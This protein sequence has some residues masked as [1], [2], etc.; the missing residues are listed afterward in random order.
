MH[1]HSEVPQSGEHAYTIQ[2]GGTADGKS[3]RDP[4]G[5]GY[6]Q[7][8]WENNVALSMENVGHEVVVNPRIFVNGMSRWHSLE[9]IVCDLIDDGMS[10]AEK[11]RAIWEFARRHRYHNTTADDEVKD[12]VKMLNVYGYTLCWDEAYTVSNLWQAA[13]L[14]VRRGVPHGHCTTEVFYDGTHHLLDSDEH[15]LY[16]LR[17]N[18]TVAGEEDLARDHDLVKRGHAYGVLS[19]ENRQSDESAAALFV[20]EGPRSGGRPQVGTHRMDYSLR[21][22][23]ALIWQWQDRGLY[24]GYGKRPP[25]MCNGAWHFVPRLDTTFNRWCVRA[26]NARSIDGSLY[27]VDPSK[28]IRL[29]Y[30]LQTPYVI[31]GGL[32]RYAGD[33]AARCTLSRDGHSWQPIDSD[34]TLN[35]LLPSD[36]SATYDLYLR[37]EGVAERIDRITVELDLQMAPL[38]LPSLSVGENELLYTDESADRAVVLTHSWNERGDL[39]APPPPRLT[40]PTDGQTTDGTQPLFSWEPAPGAADYQFELSPSP[41]M[42]YALSPVFEK[43]ISNTPFAKQTCWRPPENGQLNPEHTYFWRVRA[44][45]DE[46]L[47]G[48][49]SDTASFTPSAPGIPLDVELHTDWQTRSQYLRWRNNPQGNTPVRYIVYA[50][51]ERGFSARDDEHEVFCGR[52]VGMETRAGNRFAETDRTELQVVGAGDF[53]VNKSYYRVISLD[54]RGTPSGP[55][56]LACASRPFIFSQPP[57]HIRAEAETHY[58]VQSLQGAGDLRCI[59]EGTHRYQSAI[60]DFDTLSFILDEGPAFISLD[61][62]SGLMVFKP[63]AHHLGLHTVTLRVQNGQGGV[64]IQG[65]DLEVIDPH[66]Q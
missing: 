48:A 65:F 11:A 64:D 66:L 32:I 51:D 52:D 1:R 21:P 8:Y 56:D 38:S 47:W 37:I 5:Y 17:D 3:M 6:Y 18:A 46:G 22:G 13:G 33:L 29:I 58:A 28:P 26:D 42:R 19:R 54:E 23:E 15:L 43:L 63:A 35:A 41:D 4:V 20:Y 50:S 49:W 27:S 62:V 10:E 9:E 44:R 59:S 57:Q 55:S 16:L 2:V 14:P 7:Q 40:G 24:H 61:R 36:G 34:G 12:T 30:R 39:V 45:S 25:R 31:V 53:M 60:R